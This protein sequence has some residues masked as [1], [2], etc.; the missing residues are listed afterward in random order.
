MK[1]K[2]MMV[3]VLL[4]ALSLGACVDDNESQSVTDLRNAKAAQL[5]ALANL[6]N[7]QAEAELI[8]ANA[9]AK[10]NEAL[11]RYQEALAADQEFETQKAKDR[12]EA[13]LEAIK[14]E[15]EN[16][17]LEAQIQAQKDQQEF[18]SL[19]NDLLK[20]L[21]NEYAAEASEL[22][23]L[24]TNLN[25]Q[26]LWLA[27]Y[28]AQ[29]I[30]QDDYN[31]QQEAYWNDLIAEAEA[32][33]KAYQEYEGLDKADLQSQLWTLAEQRT[34][35][36][37]TKLQKQ[38]A[39]N[40]AR[41]AYT[42]ARGA[43]LYSN[44]AA[45]LKTVLAAK[46]LYENNINVVTSKDIDIDKDNN[47]D[48]PYYTLKGEAVVVS[49]R[50][51]LTSDLKTAKD[52]L[53]APKAGTTAAT[54][55]YINLE[56]AQ[57]QL[58]AAQDAK[59]Q[60]LIDTWTYQVASI[61]DQI[62]AAKEDVTEAQAALD[63]FEAAIASFAGDDLKAY[64]AAIEAF[65]TSDVVTAYQK[66]IE[67]SDAADEA[68]N[69]INAEYIAVNDLYN[70][71]VDVDDEIA[72]L[73]KDIAGWK[74]NIAN[75]TNNS[76]MDVQQAEDEIARLETQIEMQQAVV[77]LAKENLDNAIAAQDEE[78]TPNTPAEDET[79]SEEQPAA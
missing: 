28:K 26:K 9:Q 29:A 3:A 62:T 58:K 68:Y 57:A 49:Y 18:L 38:Q 71:G 41:T 15:A 76:E 46:Y 37:Q 50:Q 25:N 77:D 6:Y 52:Y 59:D 2:L 30:A 1:K 61:N 45:T 64:D 42:D 20:D 17:L 74:Q 24:K 40:T 73:N 44:D 7:N 23:D 79:P 66:A 47:I 19:A 43:F 72:N 10:Y 60:G 67:E 36:N 22:G 78:E 33:I 21:Y 14:L 35:A 48:V 34:L 56:N 27:Q 16:R 65:K 55:L 39:E 70:V 54:G 75:L 63:D 5:E 8:K 69:D 53:G 51:S 11:A 31:A 32:K 12:Y 13:E 4:G